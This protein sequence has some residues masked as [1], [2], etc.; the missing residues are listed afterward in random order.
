MVRSTGEDY[1][2]ASGRRWDEPVDI[3][4]KSEEYDLLGSLAG[5]NRLHGA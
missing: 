1:H 4:A 2:E 5:R 3:H